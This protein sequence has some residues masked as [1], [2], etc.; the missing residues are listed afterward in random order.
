M[1][2]KMMRDENAALQSCI[3]RQKSKK[4]ASLEMAWVTC[5]ASQ[6]ARILISVSLEKQIEGALEH[7]TSDDARVELITLYPSI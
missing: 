7:F 1:R 3:V 4:S 2:G 6:C 5:D